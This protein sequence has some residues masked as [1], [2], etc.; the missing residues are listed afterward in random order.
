MFDIKKM[1]GYRG[2]MTGWSV[3]VAG[4]LAGCRVVGGG[5]PKGITC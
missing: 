2:G 4:R 1:D 3:A 5:A